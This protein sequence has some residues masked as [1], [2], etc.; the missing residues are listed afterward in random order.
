LEESFRFR[1]ILK[2]AEE[3]RLKERRKQPGYSKVLDKYIKRNEAKMRRM[4]GQL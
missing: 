3:A 4:R 1:A 2:A